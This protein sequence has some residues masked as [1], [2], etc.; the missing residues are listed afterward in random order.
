MDH[1]YNTTRDNKMVTL[2]HQNLPIRP[3]IKRFLD[4]VCFKNWP[5]R[6]SGL[7]LV[8][9]DQTLQFLQQNNVKNFHPENSTR[10]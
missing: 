2:K 6:A 1:D 7:F 3:F 8:V 5:F 9:N 10:N 4:Y